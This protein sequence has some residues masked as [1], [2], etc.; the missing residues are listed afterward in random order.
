[1]DP[2]I[3]V[4]LYVTP[5]LVLLLAASDFYLHRKS[6]QNIM[7]Q[8]RQNVRMLN[9]QQMLTITMVVIDQN[10]RRVAKNRVYFTIRDKSDVL[11]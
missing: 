9:L 5:V 4:D 2:S 3:S 11:I 8:Q 6:R 7:H 1:M 10:G